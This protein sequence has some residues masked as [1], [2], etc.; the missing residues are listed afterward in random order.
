MIREPIEEN[1][2]VTREE[3]SKAII[4]KSETYNKHAHQETDVRIMKHE[5]GHKTWTQN[6][7]DTRT[8]QVIK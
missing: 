5:H 3:P 2:L 1:Q 8:L 4:N 7:P 6:N